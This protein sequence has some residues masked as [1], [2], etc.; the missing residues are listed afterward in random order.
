MHEEGRMK[1]Q[2]SLFRLDPIIFAPTGDVYSFFQVTNLIQT[3]EY[4]QENSINICEAY[5][6]TCRENSESTVH[7]LHKW[8]VGVQ[9]STLFVQTGFVFNAVGETGFVFNAVGETV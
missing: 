6:K 1:A 8:W 5:G 7:Y 3:Y 4:L 9:I 2:D